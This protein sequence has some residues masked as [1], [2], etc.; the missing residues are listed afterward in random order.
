MCILYDL[1][2]D[3]D[4][5]KHRINKY[6]EKFNKITTKKKLRLLITKYC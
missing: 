6:T 2:M 5:H 4:E 3:I 1:E